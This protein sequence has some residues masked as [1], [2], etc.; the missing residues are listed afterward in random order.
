MTLK[1]Y[2][3]L[4]VEWLESCTMRRLFQSNNHWS[5]VVRNQSHCEEVSYS[6]HNSF[7]EKD[8]LPCAEFSDKSADLFHNFVDSFRDTIMGR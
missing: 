3:R 5:F 1:T 8:F 6:I 7:K 4:R 2:F